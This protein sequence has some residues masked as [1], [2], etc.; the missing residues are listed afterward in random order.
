VYLDSAIIVKLLVDEPDTTSLVRALI[1]LPLSSSELAVPEVLS[2][3]LGKE[4][5]KLISATQRQ[6]AWQH[7]NE[8]VSIQEIVLHPLNGIALKKANQI[9]DRCHPGVPLRTL[10]A[11]HVAACDLSQDFPLCT[12]DRRMRDAAKV[13]GIPVFP[14]EE[15]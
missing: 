13:L 1:G 4:R 8:R 15:A 12:T 3:L 7:F 2:A 11:L 6:D 10:D 5:N 14:M 9:L